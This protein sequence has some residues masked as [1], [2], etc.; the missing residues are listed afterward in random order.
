VKSEVLIKKRGLVFK[1]KNSPPSH[2]MEGTPMQRM[3]HTAGVVDDVKY[4]Y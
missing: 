2:A 4:I 3:L 1:K